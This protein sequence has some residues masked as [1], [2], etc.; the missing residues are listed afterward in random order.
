MPM[1]ACLSA[2]AAEVAA[3]AVVAVLGAN[4]FNGLS[5]PPPLPLLTK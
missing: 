4:C 2:S 1:L 3:A 5:L